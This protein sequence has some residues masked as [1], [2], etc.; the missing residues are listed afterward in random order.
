MTFAFPTR[1]LN[2]RFGAFLKVSMPLGRL[3]YLGMGTWM[4]IAMGRWSPGL[5]VPLLACFLPT[6]LHL[7]LALPRSRAITERHPYLLRWIYGVP[8]V[9][10]VAWIL[11]YS[12]APVMGGTDGNNLGFHLARMFHDLDA[13]SRNQIALG[14]FALAVALLGRATWSWKTRGWRE[15]FVRRPGLT[16]ATLLV[17]P[18]ALG[19]AIAQCCSVLSLPEGVLDGAGVLCARD[20]LYGIR[21][22]TLVDTWLIPHRHAGASAARLRRVRTPGPACPAMVAN[23]YA[24]LSFSSRAMALRMSSR[25]SSPVISRSIVSGPV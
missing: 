22:G 17:A 20:A 18:V 6:I 15:A 2:G 16:M 9:G 13:G 5:T 8:A 7:A 21:R 3:A 4:I 1:F 24:A 14:G 11:V 10:I 19:V 12:V 25:C 23:R